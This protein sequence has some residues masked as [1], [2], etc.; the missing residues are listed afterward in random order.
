M[1]YGS[2]RLQHILI[3][4]CL[5]LSSLGVQPQQV[6]PGHVHTSGELMPSLSRARLLSWRQ[7]TRMVSYKQIQKGQKGHWLS[8]QTCNK[9]CLHS[10]MYLPR[11]K[12]ARLPW[13][14][15]RSY[16]TSWSLS[17]GQMAQGWIVTLLCRVAI[18]T[19][20]TIR[21]GPH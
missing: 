12:P 21:A 19:P 11:L 15:G 18:L 10:L 7:T 3:C 9:P 17:A 4:S 20:L 16:K 14:G 2:A 1:S 13:T 8:V 6:R 5:G